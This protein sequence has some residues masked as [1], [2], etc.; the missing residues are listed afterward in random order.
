MAEGDVVGEGT[1][2]EVFYDESLLAAANLHPPS[3]VRVARRAD[4]DRPPRPVTE[5]DL[6]ARL[7]EEGAEGVPPA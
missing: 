6:L 4:L 3:T 7:S 5:R 1:P 2:R